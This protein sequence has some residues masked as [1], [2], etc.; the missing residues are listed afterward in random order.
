[1]IE[2][3]NQQHLDLKRKNA[4]QLLSIWKEELERNEESQEVLK[5]KSGKVELE[6]EGKK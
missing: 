1:M 6:E 5:I 4:L 3:K 2:E